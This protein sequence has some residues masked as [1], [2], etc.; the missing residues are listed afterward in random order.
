MG[1]EKR[2]PPL[3]TGP[4]LLAS[5]TFRAS[6][7]TIAFGG[8]GNLGRSSPFICEA[9]CAYDCPSLFIWSAASW[10]TFSWSAFRAARLAADFARTEAESGSLWAE[11]AASRF[12]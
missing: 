12:A 3:V 5:P 7:G 6:V 8:G 10:R 9:D 1:A 11:I 2:S 4:T